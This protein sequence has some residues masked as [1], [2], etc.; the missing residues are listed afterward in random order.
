M[1]KR[2]AKVPAAELRRLERI[3]ELAGASRRAERALERAIRAALE[4][5]ISVRKVAAAAGIPPMNVWRLARPGAGQPGLDAADV[6]LPAPVSKPKD[7]G[8]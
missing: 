7:A 5:G 2:A 3:R 1:V 4:R 8:K 6:K